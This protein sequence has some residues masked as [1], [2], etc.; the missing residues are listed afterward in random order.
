MTEREWSRD[1]CTCGHEDASHADLGRGRCT[2]CDS[3][4][5]WEK[6]SKGAP[7]TRYQWNGE[8]RKRAW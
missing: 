4:A 7:C 1:V 3:I 8:P 5:S 6:P 2:R